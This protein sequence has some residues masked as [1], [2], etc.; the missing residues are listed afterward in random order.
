[1]KMPNQEVLLK[2]GNSPGLCS[3]DEVDEVF[4]WLSEFNTHLIA[5]K[6]A[7]GEP[8]GHSVEVLIAKAK[9][10]KQNA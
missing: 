5:Y 1:M 2:F 3:V 8:A 9:W 6:A 7:F 10:Y 4:N